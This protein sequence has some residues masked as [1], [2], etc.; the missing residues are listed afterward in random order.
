MKH[1]THYTLAQDFKPSAAPS[2]APAAAPAPAA[3]AAAK[4]APPPPAAP[5]SPVAVNNAAP[6]AGASV[7]DALKGKKFAFSSQFGLATPQNTY[8]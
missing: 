6:K 5:T 3:P 1:L 7:M 8:Y 4:A 2:A